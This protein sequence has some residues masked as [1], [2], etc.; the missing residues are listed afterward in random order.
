MNDLRLLPPAAKYL[1]KLKDKNLKRLF[2]DAIFSIVEDPYIGDE[3]TPAADFTP[4]PVFFSRLSFLF[5]RLIAAAAVTAATASAAAFTGFLAF[6]QGSDTKACDGCH[7]QQN[8]HCR[9]IHKLPL[10]LCGLPL[11]QRH[12][13]I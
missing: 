10:P 5:F 6:D 3:K 1:K 12:G 7:H 8:N 2:Q 4:Q 11:C 9:N 13:L